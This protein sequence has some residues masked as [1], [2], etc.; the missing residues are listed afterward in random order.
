MKTTR[1]RAAPKTHLMPKNNASK[2]LGKS[3]MEKV[4]KILESKSEFE[5]LI[6]SELEDKNVSEGSKKSVISVPKVCLVASIFD[7]LDR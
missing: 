2:D 6:K 5:A 1:L 7:R 3:A 4:K